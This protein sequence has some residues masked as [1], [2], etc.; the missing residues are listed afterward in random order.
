MSKSKLR[1][2]RKLGVL[3]TVF[4]VSYFLVLNKKTISQ[5]LEM[6]FGTRRHTC[7]LQHIVN[8][9]CLLEIAPLVFFTTSTTL[10]WLPDT[11]APFE[12]QKSSF[13]DGSRGKR[14]HRPRSRRQGRR[15]A[16]PQADPKGDFRGSRPNFKR[17]IPVNMNYFIN[18]NKLYF[19]RPITRHFWSSSSPKYVILFKVDS[20]FTY[21]TCCYKQRKKLRFLQNISLFN[22]KNLVR[23]M[24]FTRR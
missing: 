4:T 22:N 12:G 15:E 13:G 17:K 9:M 21:Y 19:I 18:N 3:W 24:L 11:P 5:S 16:R 14:G 10:N 20:D 7:T 23:S 8:V 6:Q 1:I 2:S